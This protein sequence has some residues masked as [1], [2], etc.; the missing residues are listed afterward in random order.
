MPNSSLRRAKSMLYACQCGSITR[1]LGVCALYS[2]HPQ[3]QQK[4]TRDKKL[5]GAPGIATRNKDATRNMCE[6]L[7]TV[8]W[9]LF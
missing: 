3:T 2:T 5:L 9:R 8:R 7:H 1:V 6:K 4:V